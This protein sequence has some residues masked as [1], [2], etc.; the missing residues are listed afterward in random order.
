MRLEDP[1]LRGQRVDTICG[2]KAN[3][4][5]FRERNE[6]WAKCFSSQREIL[7]TKKFFSVY[8]GRPPINNNMLNWYE[9]STYFYNFYTRNII[10]K[11]K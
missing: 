11:S 9:Y 7:T 5:D 2:T 10:I 4:I 1:L 3:E 6:I 8:V